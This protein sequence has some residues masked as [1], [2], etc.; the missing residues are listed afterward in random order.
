MPPIFVQ[1]LLENVLGRCHCC[2]HASLSVYRG[3]GPFLWVSHTFDGKLGSHQV[4]Q[5]LA[6]QG[7]CLAYFFLVAGVVGMLSV[8]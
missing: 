3:L 7:V 8:D 2:L 4:T 1:L 6:L 5:H